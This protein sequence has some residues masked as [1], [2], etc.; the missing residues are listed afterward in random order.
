M[1]RGMNVFRRSMCAF[2][3][4]ALTLSLTT[5]LGGG[6]LA[7]AQHEVGRHDRVSDGSDSPTT[8]I[9]RWSPRVDKRAVGLDYAW[10]PQDEWEPPVEEMSWIEEPSAPRSLLAHTSQKWRAIPVRGP[11]A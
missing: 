10:I 4:F 6:P 8:W 3:C 5:F 2:L 9:G 7:D 1:F 11:P